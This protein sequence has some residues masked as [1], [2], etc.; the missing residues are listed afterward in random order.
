MVPGSSSAPGAR[1][2]A[3]LRVPERKR[4]THAVPREDLAAMPESTPAPAAPPAPAP[5]PAAAAAP[6]TP[7]P[8]ETSAAA[9]SPVEARLVLEAQEAL[10]SSP[11][12][13]LELC[14]EHARR[15]P[16]GRLAEEREPVAIEALMRLGRAAEARA[17]AR[18]FLDEHPRSVHALRVHRVLDEAD[19]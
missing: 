16:D 5:A 3:R 10:R 11:A 1:P 17:R 18:R 15:F 6:A 13:A 7:R 19:R 12:R 2:H 9:P 8:D 4:A 14:A